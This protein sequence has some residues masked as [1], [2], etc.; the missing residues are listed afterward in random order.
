MGNMVGLIIRG[1]GQ[2]VSNY[3]KHLTIELVKRLV[4]YDETSGVFIVREPRGGLIKGQRADRPKGDG[5][6][7]VS[8]GGFQVPAH[9][10]AWFYVYNYWPRRVKHV[11]KDRGDN[12]IDNLI[13]YIKPEANKSRKIRKPRIDGDVTYIPLTQNYEAVIDTQ[14]LHM[15]EGFNWYAR[16][17]GEVVYAGRRGRTETGKVITIHMHRVISNPDDKQQ[18]DHIDHNGLNNRRCNL[19]NCTPA[20]NQY[21][22]RMGSNNTSGYKGAHWCKR[23]RKWV[24]AMRIDGKRKHLGYYSSAEDAHN[25]YC[26]ACGKLTDVFCDGRDVDER[27]SE[28]S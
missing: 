4:I 9:Y 5:S 23:S 14:D 18:V 11:N 10:L 6:L 27:A 7:R 26:E 8:V 3:K 24:A 20:E 22:R 12:S 1:R 15:V 16:K 25:A 2:I 17:S 21:N 13:E 28:I 19:R